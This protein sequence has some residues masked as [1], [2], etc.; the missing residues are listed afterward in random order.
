MKCLCNSQRVLWIILVLEEEAEAS[1]GS[2]FALTVLCWAWEFSVFLTQQVIIPKY[3]SLEIKFYAL[4]T[5]PVSSKKLVL[6]S[7][8]NQWRLQR[9]ASLLLEVVCSRDEIAFL[10]SCIL[11]IW[12]LL[13]TVSHKAHRIPFG[14]H[15]H[16]VRRQS[17]GKSL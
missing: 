7:W 1:L 11:T 3:A 14:C 10:H 9:E 5:E 15:L 13:C 6:I 4:S 12:L 8:M 16:L 17:H 2:G